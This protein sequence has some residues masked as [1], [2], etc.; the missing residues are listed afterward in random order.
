[1]KYIFYA[2]LLLCVTNFVYAQESSRKH[3]GKIIEVKGEAYLEEEGKSKRRLTVRD[4]GT[5]L[6]AEQILRCGS[7]CE[8]R[9]SIGS[10]PEKLTEGRYIVPNLGRPSSDDKESISAGSKTRGVNDILLAPVGSDVGFVRPE[11]FKFR[12]RMLKINSVLINISPLT[13]SLYDCKTADLIWSQPDI[14]YQQGSYAPSEV[15]KL[16]K[17]RQQPNSTTSIEVVVTSDSFDKKQRFCFNIISA[18]EEQ[19]LQDK[20]AKWDNYADLIQYIERARIF[21]KH[22]LYDEA[23]AEYDLALT[24]S[25][26]TD[27]LVAAAIKAHHLLGDQDKV[28]DLLNRLRELSPSSNLYDEMLKLTGQGDKN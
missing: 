27:Y 28:K 11:S 5:F 14:D 8:I 16:L 1:M 13:I 25:P 26:S 20:L 6:F 23:S 17:K 3:V 19:L 10:T 22:K 9:F 18:A 2:L 7:N 15:Q 24:L 21:Y 12:W 4:K